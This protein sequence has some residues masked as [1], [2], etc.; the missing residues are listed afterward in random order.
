MKDALEWK[1]KQE[2]FAEL[3]NDRVTKFGRHDFQLWKKPDGSVGSLTY[4]QVGRIVK[5]MAAGLMSLGIM[6]GDR[7]ALMSYNCP[8]WLWADFSIVNAGA[9]SATV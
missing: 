7:V 5:E 2:T 1:I 8:E 4:A 3:F 6:A 9:V